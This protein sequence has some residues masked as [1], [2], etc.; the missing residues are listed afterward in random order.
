MISKP[1]DVG[2]QTQRH[3]TAPGTLPGG[4]AGPAPNLGWP[5]RMD[6]ALKESRGTEAWKIHLRAVE[7]TTPR[8]V[9]S[10]G[11]RSVVKP[12]MESHQLWLNWGWLIN[13]D[14]PWTT[15]SKSW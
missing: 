13:I 9:N 6:Q 3:R 12:T 14:L 8:G 5:Q 4:Q 2:L 1:H 11:V 7:W 15:M 10:P